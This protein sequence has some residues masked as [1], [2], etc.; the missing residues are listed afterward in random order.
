LPWCATGSIV[1]PSWVPL[2][3]FSERPPWHGGDLQTMRNQLMD[4]LGRGPADP[5][6]EQARRLTF[7]MPDG[8]GD[9]LSARFDPP[10]S[11]RPAPT[12]VLIHGLT[13]CERS[14]YA[15]ASAA[16]LS[17]RGYGVLR[18]NLRGAGPSRPLCREQYHA[19]R[20]ED[21]HALFAE[22]PVDI[23]AGGLA[24]VGYSLGGNTLLKYLGEAGDAAPL[25]AAASVSAPID[26]AATARRMMRPRNALYHRWLLQLM[27]RES[28]AP[29]AELTQGE[30]RAAL[31]ART[32]RDFDDRFVA[33]RNG[34]ASA[35]DYYEKCRALRFLGG[36]RVP[37]LL[38]HAA[39]DPWIPAEPYLAYDWA[40]APAL[41]AVVAPGGG[42]VG[43]HG[44]GSP[45][46]WHDR[47]IAAFLDSAFGER[48]PASPVAA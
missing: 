11:D 35:E 8:S 44:R 36:I 18:V 9:R 42:H 33:P 1:D 26:L 19:G 25:V 29:A 40:G 45:V 39:D 30:R 3:N 38:L 27:K 16:H 2:P 21:L 28:T 23:A 47:C 12:A 46:P 7:A 48:A 20:S 37:T 24:A 17:A 43:F 4:A 10:P 14:G 34:F 6:P 31:E 41:R 13:G 15:R 32:V 5:D 22:I